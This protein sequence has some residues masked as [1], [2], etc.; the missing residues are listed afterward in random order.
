MVLQGKQAILHPPGTYV[1]T[2][3]EKTMEMMK[4]FL[5]GI[6]RS[7]KNCDFSLSITAQ[8][9]ANHKNL[10]RKS[11]EVARVEISAH[12]P[13][14]NIKGKREGAAVRPCATSV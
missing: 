6:V 11:P 14:C 9:K 8:M 7:S 4:R 10:C 5:I 1:K 12:C 3:Q 2:I 13:A